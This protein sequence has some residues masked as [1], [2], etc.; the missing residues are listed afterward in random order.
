M[1]VNSTKVKDVK[2]ASTRSDECAYE[3]ITHEFRSDGSCDS[4]QLNPG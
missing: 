3:S 4:I 1:Y 2:S